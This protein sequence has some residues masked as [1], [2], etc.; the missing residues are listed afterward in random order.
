MIVL[1]YLFRSMLTSSSP[2]SQGGGDPE[3]PAN[4]LTFEGQGLTF[5][6]QAVTFS[7]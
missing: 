5:E 7:G 4:Q 1:L 2:I 6:G 3:L